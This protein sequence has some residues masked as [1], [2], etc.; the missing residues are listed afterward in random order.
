MRFDGW[1]Y[2]R[3]ANLESMLGR[4]RH[5]TPIPFQHFVSATIIYCMLLWLTQHSSMLIY[6]LCCV[7]QSQSQVYTRVLS[8]Y[9][10]V[11]KWI[12]SCAVHDTG[13]YTHVCL[14]L[15]LN[16]ILK[17][18]AWNYSSLSHLYAEFIPHC[19]S[20]FN[21][22]SYI[23]AVTNKISHWMYNNIW[24]YLFCLSDCVD[25]SP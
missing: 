23:V 17:M 15:V 12:P 1:A 10:T 11:T 24:K 9:T 19:L 22:S 25:L 18:W 6:F 13:S 21:V 7:T 4:W 20:C 5:F 2:L 14:L 3:S 8:S 16:P